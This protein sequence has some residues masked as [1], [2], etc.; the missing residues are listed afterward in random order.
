MRLVQNFGI[1]SDRTGPELTEIKVQSFESGEPTGRLFQLPRQGYPTLSTG[2]ATDNRSALRWLPWLLGFVLLLTQSIAPAVSTAAP[3]STESQSVTSR[4]VDTIPSQNSNPDIHLEDASGVLSEDEFQSLNLVLDRLNRLGNPTVVF[5][6]DSNDEATAD[7]AFAEDLRLGW[8]VESYPDAQNGLVIV[9]SVD[10]QNPENSTIDYSAGVNTF[11]IRRLTNEEFNGIL[12]NQTI[13]AVQEGNDFIALN[14][15]LE[16]TL[17]TVEDQ[18]GVLTE[19][20]LQILDGDL[21]RLG[22]MGVPMQVSIQPAAAS[23]NDAQQ[24][25]DQIR[26]DWAVESAPGANDGIVVVVAFDQV[27]ASNSQIAISAGENA[28]PIRQMSESDLEEIVSTKALP[29]IQDG[30]LYLGLAYVVRS[31]INFAEYTP[32]NPVP[33]TEFQQW[34]QTPMNIAAAI[35]V[36]LALIGYFLVPALVDHRLTLIPSSRSL[37]IY[38]VLTAVLALLVAGGGVVAHSRSATLAGFGVFVWAAIVAPLVRSGLN[39]FR[40]WQVHKTAPPT[41]A[42]GG[43]K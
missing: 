38:A 35:L 22:Q 1:D 14:D 20:Q 27:D 15:L 4:Q 36:Q 21:R 11:P 6:R 9:L 24:Q 37:A 30:D 10:R 5:V 32:P 16:M 39:E 43:S 28:F 3:I 33:I 26:S 31:T 19:R 2:H 29:A 34:L 42:A 7:A 13:P 23:A 12:T 18:V 40:N 8:S 17:G 41:Q 25:A